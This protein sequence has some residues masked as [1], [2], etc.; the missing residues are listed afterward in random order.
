MQTIFDKKGGAV[1]AT[2]SIFANFDIKD[3]QTAEAFVE[4]LET[5]AA[6]PVHKPSAPIEILT[7]SEDIKKLWARRKKKNI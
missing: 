2:S 3:K 6:E 7:R 5:S 4:A 1:M